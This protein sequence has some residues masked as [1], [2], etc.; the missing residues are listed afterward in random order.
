MHTKNFFKL[1]LLLLVYY[2]S[3]FTPNESTLR[4][5]DLAFLVAAVPL[6]SGR[7]IRCTQWIQWPFFCLFLF[8]IEFLFRKKLKKYFYDLYKNKSYGQPTYLLN[9]QITWRKHSHFNFS[10][11]YTFC[12]IS[13]KPIHSR[14]TT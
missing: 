4:A 3:L 8:S 10:Y 14:G 12:T 6:V 2:L 5:G 13:P 7:N 1:P 9:E 11:T